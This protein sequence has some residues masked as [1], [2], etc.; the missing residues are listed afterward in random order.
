MR[1][2]LL[3][4]FDSF[5]YNLAHYCEGMGSLVDVLD[6]E[7]FDPENISDYNAV[8]LSPGPGLPTDAG[9]LLPTVVKAIDRQI[10]LLG[11]CLGMQA[12]A[13]HYQGKLYNQQ[14]VK[15]GLAEWM[16]IDKMDSRLYTGL[17]K[18]QQI[19][20]YHSWAV[21]LNRGSELIPTAWSESG[22]LMSVEHHTLPIYG[23]QFHPESILT[24][25]GKE[26]IRNF[27]TI[28]S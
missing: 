7:T 23:V 15:H 27:L 5:T 19:G 10:P 28:V 6:N 20:L 13:E 22:V 14:Q 8:I 4:N 16:N 24:I 9:V 17:D 11:V 25:H 12:I 1:I 21:D 26:M 2:L 3:D 18:R